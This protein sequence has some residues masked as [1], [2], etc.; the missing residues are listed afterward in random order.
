[1]IWYVLTFIAGFAIGMILIGCLLRYRF[2]IFE[3]SMIE[4]LNALRSYYEDK[5]NVLTMYDEEEK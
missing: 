3:D 2:S 4:S 5:I 1:M